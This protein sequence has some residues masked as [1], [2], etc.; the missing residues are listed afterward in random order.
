MLKNLSL[1][2]KNLIRSL[3]AI[4]ILLVLILTIMF[5][6]I[7]IYY[8]PE[9]IK[10]AEYQVK[11]RAK[12]ISFFVQKYVNSTKVLAELLEKN[13]EI[14]EDD[15]ALSEWLKQNTYVDKNLD[16]LVFLN[17]NGS[18]INKSGKRV[19][20]TEKKYG[21]WI[22]LKS[23]YFNYLLTNNKADA[24][25]TDHIFSP[26]SK[27]KD[28]EVQVD[29]ATFK[30][31]KNR[32]GQPI[33]ALAS[34]VKVDELRAIATATKIASFT[35]SFLTDS[36]AT[37]IAHKSPKYIG[38]W[39]L[40]EK[41]E[42]IKDL[43]KIA[44]TF[45]DNPQFQI[46]KTVSAPYEYNP[47]QGEFELSIF[48]A[49][50][51][52]TLGWAL[53]SATPDILLNWPI[54]LTLIA[55]GIIF[56]VS[57]LIFFWFFVRMNLYFN[58]NIGGIA[59]KLAE[60]TSGDGD[61]TDRIEKLPG[62][63]PLAKLVDNFNSF[64]QTIGVFV[65]DIIE[66][67]K[68][69]N[70]YSYEISKS[71]D[72]MNQSMKLQEEEIEQ[73]SVSMNQMVLSVTEVANY[74][75]NAADTAKEGASATLVGT[76]SVKDVIESIENQARAINATAVDMESLQ[77]AG[78]SI[79]DVIDVINAIAE[80]TNL[81]ALNA[82]IEAA[83]AGEAGRGFAVVADEVRSLAARTHKSTNEISQTVNNLRASIEKSATTMSSSIETSNK[84]VEDANK[85]GII[86]GK[87]EASIKNLEELNLLIA[88]S[89]E[90]QKDRVTDLSANLATIIDVANISSN[91][92]HLLKSRGV[93]LEISAQ[94]LQNLVNRFKV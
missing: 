66:S 74:A 71:S 93:N 38:E 86:L 15:F 67:S 3:V 11:T 12:A 31:V 73:I 64:V 23:S 27:N 82:A 70:G 6:A 83:R 51:E 62:N 24:L 36:Q 16:Q 4:V 41:D 85:T 57:F 35:L 37:V 80:Q 81:L 19:D 90:D 42:G 59:Q 47:T 50:I 88:Q 78:S 77:D 17:L 28:G 20:F 43:A 7:R 56:L 5:Y 60:I 29:F 61:L 49:P 94:K 30:V 39:N 32:E 53:G 21:N 75:Q 48:L 8:L 26:F 9:I 63:D 14:V 13:P 46:L 65:K 84:S 69:L 91:S 25:V 52:G 54:Y 33:G 92:A 76:K 45:I 10:S 40:F 72:F 55:I 1:S 79:G 58:K 44:Q 68:S 89:T 2:K 34:L 87:L 22:H 18:L